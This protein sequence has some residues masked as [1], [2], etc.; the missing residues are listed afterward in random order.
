MPASTFPLSCRKG[1]EPPKGDTTS[2]TCPTETRG[3]RARL[4]RSEELFEFKVATLLHVFVAVLGRL[5]NAIK[6]IIIFVHKTQKNKTKTLDSI[7]VL[8]KSESENVTF[9]P[10]MGLART[11]DESCRAA[12]DVPFHCW[13][14][15]SECHLRVALDRA[16]PSSPP[17]TEPGCLFAATVSHLEISFPRPRAIPTHPASP[18]APPPPGDYEDVS[19]LARP[20]CE[21][22]S[23]GMLRPSFRVFPK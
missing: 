14:T 3:R 11:G 22:V 5:R 13:E 9:L 17:R 18:T 12:T 15:R 6:N 21:V 19:D 7:Y 20:T 2:P 16:P 23:M 10:T 1:V 8:I 4:R